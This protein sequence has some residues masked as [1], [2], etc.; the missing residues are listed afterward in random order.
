MADVS[1][2][3]AA[4]GREKWE[5][6]GPSQLLQQS[7]DA[8]RVCQARIDRRCNETDRDHR[9]ESRDAPLRAHV[10]ARIPIFVFLIVLLELAI[11]QASFRRP[12]RT[13]YFT[14]LIVGVLLTGTITYLFFDFSSPVPGS[15]HNLETAIQS[16]RGVVARSRVMAMYVEYPSL[17]AA[18]GF[19]TC[20]LGILPAWAAGALASRWMSPME[21]AGKRMGPLHRWVSSRGDHRFGTVLLPPG[22]PWPFSSGQGFPLMSSGSG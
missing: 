12:L 22:C 17:A 2:P 21:R 6:N 7:T 3:D 11:V 18:D 10:G 1:R 4:I 5:V 19:I 9:L 15:L 13:F 8:E 20:L 16:R 14:F